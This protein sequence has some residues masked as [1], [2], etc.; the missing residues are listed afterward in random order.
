MEPAGAEL[1][2]KQGWI[3]LPS[4]VD[5]ATVQLVQQSLARVYPT[6]E[7]LRADPRSHRWV[8]EGQFGALR[9][10]PLDDLVLDL[11]PL[12]PRIVATAETLLGTGDIRLL[13]AGY[14]A[15][16]AATV[17][18]TQVL[19]YDYP[20]HSLVV[21]ADDDIVGFF[22]Y[23]S[24]ITEDLGP[25]M[26]VSDEVRGA[27]SPERTHPD[28]SA[29]PG[30]YAAERPAVGTAGSLLA[31]RS[32]TYHRGSAITAADGVRLTVSFAYGRTSPWTGYTAF[33]RLGEE[34]GLINTIVAA[35]A[36]QRALLG[37]PA[38]GDPYWTPRTLDAVT[39]RYPG[40]DPSPYR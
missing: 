26:L 19:H 36:G 4:V 7:E 34:A 27:I 14:Q 13:R 8:T 35:T 17:D 10:W 28:P 15:K 37:F 39:R 21:P 22:L 25:T 9:L 20:N 23:L 38:V 6:S 16:Y 33:P 40:L 31:Y 5:A 2:A 18:Y 3:L 30:L 24:D 32:T 29:W 12:D 11:L 1:F